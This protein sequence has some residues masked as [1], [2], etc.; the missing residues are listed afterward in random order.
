MHCTHEQQV[1]LDELLLAKYKDM[2]VTDDDEPGYTE[3]VKH[4]IFTS[5]DIPVNQP[6]RR[7]P[8][9]QYQEAKEY[10]QKL[11]SKGIIQESHSPHSSP[12]VL[13]RKKNGSLPMCVD[14]RKLNA[15]TL[16]DA[17]P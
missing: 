5:D 14:Y 2:F 8:P 16:K 7:I 4:K 3:T 9:G 6:F 11:I 17:Y 15:K 10:I 12:I 13:V 1:K